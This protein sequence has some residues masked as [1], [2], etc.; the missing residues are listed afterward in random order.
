MVESSVSKISVIESSEV[1]SSVVEPSVRDSAVVGS[2]Q[3][4]SFLTRSADAGVSTVEF[5]VFQMLS[6]DDRVSSGQVVSG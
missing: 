5:G 4:R 6:K 1:G 3:V 2:C